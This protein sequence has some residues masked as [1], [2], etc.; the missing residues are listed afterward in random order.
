MHIPKQQ[1]GADSRRLLLT[2][3]ANELIDRDGAFEVVSV[4]KGANVSTGLIYRW[5]DS[6]SGL[7]AAVVDDFYD[8]LDAAVFDTNPA[9][10]ATWAERERER[11][12]L[13]V[14]FH[15]DDPLAPV[16]L[17]RLSRQ[18]PV[19]AIEQDRI[20]R[21]IEAATHNLQL[22]QKR[23]EIPK[24]LDAELVGAMVL[25]GMREVLR[26]ALAR[27]PRP[28]REQVESELWRFISAA[29]RHRPEAPKKRRRRAEGA[30]RE[31]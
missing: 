2:A 8:R 5:F 19:A 7:L 16:L 14:A 26:H 4:A 28:P 12:R 20:E 3:A 25:G 6:K 21:H 10:G 29:V 17:S 24:D 15:Y 18:P 11:T 27:D 22:G 9:P 13:G 31:A 23:R 1:R 30:L